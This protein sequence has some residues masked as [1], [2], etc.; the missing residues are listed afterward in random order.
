MR[1][2]YVLLTF[3]FASFLFACDLNDS[4]NSGMEIPDE[5][6]TEYP[7]NELLPDDG[8][9]SKEVPLNEIWYNS[10]NNSKLDVDNGVFGVSFKYAEFDDLSG[11]WKLVFD[12]EVQSIGD[13]AFAKCIA[14]TKIVLPNSIRKI[15][16]DAFSECENLRSI[17]LGNSLR[18]IKKRA[19]SNCHSLEAIVIPDTVEKLGENTFQNCLSLA[20][21]K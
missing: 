19:F 18:E 7:D 9:L 20:E 17:S 11:Y 15:G 6:Q 4:E 16:I 21:V 8:G 10:K 12:G 14:L 2:T 5:G 13:K 1:F 3:V